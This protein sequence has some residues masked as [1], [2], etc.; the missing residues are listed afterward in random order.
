MREIRR[1]HSR[2][3][4]LLLCYLIRT[5]TVQ[6]QGVDVRKFQISSTA[7]TMDATVSDILQQHRTNKQKQQQQ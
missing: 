7:M 3:I 5:T 4:F 6:Q 1:T 2:T